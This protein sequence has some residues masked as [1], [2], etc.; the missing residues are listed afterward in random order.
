[1]SDTYQYD[2]AFSFLTVDESIAAQLHAKLKGRLASF[3]YADTERQ[4]MIAGRDGDGVYGR[5]FGEQARTVVVLYRADWGKTGFTQIESTAIRNRAFEQGY[6]FVTFINRD[7]SPLPPWIPKPRVWIG[8]DRLGLD[9]AAA[10]IES[11]VQEAGGESHEETAID[12]AERMH[13]ERLAETE[14]ASFLGSQDGATAALDGCQQIFNHLRTFSE[15]TYTHVAEPKLIRRGSSFVFEIAAAYC[16]WTIG[17]A[18]NPANYTRPGGGEL[19]VREW[20][21]TPEVQEP[22]RSM[23]FVPDY[24]QGVSGWME[25]R[26]QAKFYRHDDVADWIGQRLLTRIEDERRREKRRR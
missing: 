6:E 23:S 22:S 18:W 17:V 11:R 4:R 1:M 21:G 7:G 2:V 8:L 15:H 9:A 13:A 16:H 20:N 12:R 24:R 3:F 5:V 25:K 19:I 26:N 14:R 10:V